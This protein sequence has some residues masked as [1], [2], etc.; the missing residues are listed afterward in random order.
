MRRLGTRL[1]FAL[2]MCPV[3][4]RCGRPIA[5]CEVGKGEDGKAVACCSLQRGQRGAVSLNIW[6]RGSTATVA[7]PG[8]GC[9]TYRPMHPWLA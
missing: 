8:R 1:V 5:Y 9:I 2:H 4:S 3:C 6:L 7:V